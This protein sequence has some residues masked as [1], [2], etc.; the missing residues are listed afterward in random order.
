M[1]AVFGILGTLCSVYSLLIF[2]RIIFSWFGGGY[3]KIEEFLS[4]ITDPYLN[5]F[6]R[7]TFLRIGRIDFSPVAALIVLSLFNQILFSLAAAAALKIGHILSILLRIVWSSVSFFIIALAIVLAI[8][9]F[10]YLT[11]QNTFSRF[12]QTIDSISKPVNYRINRIIFGK[13]IVNFLTGILVSIGILILLAFLGR[14]AINF[15]ASLLDK[16]PF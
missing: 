2:V 14:Y 6:R 3:G 16:M 8:R 12:W 15:L 9:L 10:G 11:R 1:R 7:L 4:R 13:R 5:W